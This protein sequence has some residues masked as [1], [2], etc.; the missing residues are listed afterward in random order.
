MAPPW[1][2]A[3]AGGG[4]WNVATSTLSDGVH[5]ITARATDLA[6]N[7]NTSAALS[8]TIDTVGTPPVVVG[9]TTDSGSSSTDGITNDTTLTVSGT[10]EANAAVKVFDGA[11]LLSTV[12]A[13][14]A[15]TWSYVDSRTLDE[16]QRSQLHRHRDR[17]RREHERR[18]EHLRGHDRYHSAGRALGPRPDRRHRHR[19]V[20]HR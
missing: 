2:A 13:S 15:G 19:I 1:L 9:I 14:A 16:W 18:L 7:Q 8:V 12:T 11:T 4:N 5:S 10:A 17:C 6:G 3:P 20:E